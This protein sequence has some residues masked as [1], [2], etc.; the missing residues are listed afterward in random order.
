MGNTTE[1]TFF[2]LAAYGDH[3]Q[4]K[5]LYFSCLLLLYITICLANIMLIS[6]IYVDRSLH[7]PMYVFLCSLFMNELHGS[8]TFFS[9]LLLHILADTHEIAIAYCNVQSFFLHAYG[10]T[11]MYNLAV[12]AYDRYLSICHP[13]HYS[14]RMNSCKM[15]SLIVFTWSFS[16]FKFVIPMSLRLQLPLCGNIIDKLYCANYALVRLSC[17]NIFL[18]NILGVFSLVL[19]VAVPLIPILFSY[20]N[21]VRISYKSPKEAQ[22]KAL[23]TC[24]PQVISLLY[25]SVSGFFEMVETQFDLT[26]VPQ[27]IR[28]VCMVYLFACPQILNPVMYGVRL[29][30]IRKAFKKRFFPNST[31]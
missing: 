24:S 6:L 23:N 20:V 5:Y 29:T 26:Y 13:L 4:I 7:E 19:S 11:E 22:V 2:I 31:E 16:F 10:T 12:M 28:N 21:I 30:K 3:G 1:V 8:T 9:V 18:N 17:Q 27:L 25:F 15:Y 14:S